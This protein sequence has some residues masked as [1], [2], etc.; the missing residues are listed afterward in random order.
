M[1][2][3]GRRL[4]CLVVIWG[5]LEGCGSKTSP[6]P[7]TAV[8]QATNSPSQVPWNGAPISA[9][10]ECVGVANTWFFAT[11]L[12][13]TAGAS[14]S[15]TSSVNTNDGLVRPA[16]TENIAVPSKGSV[17]LNRGF[18]FNQPTQHTV[19]STFTGTDASGHAI[20]VISPTVT[21]LAR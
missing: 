1:R 13:E 5:C 19:Q 4:S 6:T 14:V 21:L 7:V 16:F 15:I 3:T 20:T 9:I 2:T 12:T 10:P 18:C 11:T 8:V 17:T